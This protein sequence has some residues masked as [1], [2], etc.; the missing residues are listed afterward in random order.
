MGLLRRLAR[1]GRPTAGAAAGAGRLVEGAGAGA[2]AEAP[3]AGSGATGVNEKLDR[4]ATVLIGAVAAVSAALA[5]FGVSSDRVWTL[6]DDD[7]VSWRI[8]IAALLAVVAVGLALASYLLPAEHNALEAALL[9]AGLTAYVGGLVVALGASASA[10]DT[11]GRPSVTAVE[12]ERTDDGPVVTFT[13]HAESLD[14]DQ[15]LGARAT[16]DGATVYESTVRPTP[17]GTADLVVA[18][19]VGPSASRVLVAAWR[20]DDDRPTDPMPDCADPIADRR[21]GCALLVVPGG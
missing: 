9:A 12:L 15:R 18:L 19:P 21:A 10:A 4:V 14:P 16:V 13:V 6:L 2:G 20:L 7:A 3:S 11:P 8:T 1:R 5:L 17:R